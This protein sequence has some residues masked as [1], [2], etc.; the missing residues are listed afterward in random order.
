[1]G[2]KT[3]LVLVLVAIVVLVNSAH[4]ESENSQYYNIRKKEIIDNLKIQVFLL[5]IICNVIIVY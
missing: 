2:D 4:S 3:R 1:M 5:K